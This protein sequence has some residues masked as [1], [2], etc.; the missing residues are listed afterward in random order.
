M[1][2]RHRNQNMRKGSCLYET[3]YESLFGV[4]WDKK[5]IEK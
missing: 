2:R 5:C 4:R 1:L 3:W